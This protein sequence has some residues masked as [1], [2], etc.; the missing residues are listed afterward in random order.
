MWTYRG[1][2][3]CCANV[4]LT[5]PTCINSTFRYLAAITVMITTAYLRTKDRRDDCKYIIKSWINV[6]GNVN[7]VVQKLNSINQ[8]QRK[9]LARQQ[10]NEHKEKS[11]HCISYIF[12]LNGY[13]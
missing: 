1:T 12:Y 4:M 9:V 13:F 5:T 11:W 2:G 6:Y 10:S 3:P 8:I 7:I